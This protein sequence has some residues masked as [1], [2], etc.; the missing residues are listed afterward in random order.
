MAKDTSQIGKTGNMSK[1]IVLDPTD[2]SKWSQ[3]QIGFDPYWHPVEGAFC[4]GTIVNK[5]DRNPNFIRYQMK[6]F[7]QVECNRGPRASGQA[8]TVKKGETFTIGVYESMKKEFDFH[9][10]MQSVVKKDIPIRIDAVDKSETNNIDEVTGEKRNVW[11][12][13]V[14]TPPEMKALLDA[15]RDKYRHLTMQV[16]EEQA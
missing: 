16:E 9:L 1:D 13:K 5:D 14:C 10:Y 11:N 12:W 3:I 15:N 7:A 8:V 6:A 4:V 2:Y